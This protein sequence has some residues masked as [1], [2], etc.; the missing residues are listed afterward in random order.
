[1]V[2]KLLLAVRP[3][4]A[5][6]GEKDWQQLAVIRRVETDLGIGVEILGHPTVREAD[7]LAMSSRNALLP[8]ERPRKSG[9]PSC[10]LAGRR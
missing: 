6:F 8:P 4:H 1:M 2:A 9:R 7:G 5:I 10:R 3:T